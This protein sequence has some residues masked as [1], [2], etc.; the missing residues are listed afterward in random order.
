MKYIVIRKYFDMG[1]TR[2]VGEVVE[3]IGDRA[4]GLL[5]KGLIEPYIEEAKL[6]EKSEKA[7]KR[8][9]K[10]KVE[11]ADESGE[12]NNSDN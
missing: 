10:K 4:K 5:G 9:R 11:V 8:T 7:V 2:K 1:K 12:G 3:L 6:E